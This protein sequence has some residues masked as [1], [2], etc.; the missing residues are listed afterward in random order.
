MTTVRI[1]ASGDGDRVT[2]NRLLG[3][4]TMIP[5]R[6]I[7]L[8]E[9]QFLVDGLFRQGPPAGNGAVAYRLNNPLFAD[10]DPEIVE[11]YGEIPVVGTS[12]GLLKTVGTVKRGFAL[13]VSRE[14]RD[15]NDTATLNL[16][17]Q[18]LRNSMVRAW[19]RAFMNLIDSNTGG[20]EGIHLMAAGDGLGKTS[21]SWTEPASGEDPIRADL[22]AAMEVIMNSG[23]NG[24]DDGDDIFE[25][26]AN[27]LVI[28]TTVAVN[29][30]NNDAVNEVFAHGALADE[31][32]K[33]TGK[34]PRKFF[35]L[36]V[37][38]SR[39]LNKSGAALVMQR[40]IAGF[41]SDE[42][43]LEATAMYP[44]QDRETWRSNITRR[45]AIALDQPKA[46]VRIDGVANPA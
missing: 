6:Q 18:Q 23:P 38:Q 10:E 4:P 31:Q 5:E 22:A 44:D 7:R 24:I 32:L 45:S 39:A 43:P 1:Q 17:M 36:D 21:T 26:E 2:V 35:G 16:R 28:P 14:M 12:R 29:F 20:D 8:L 37:V 41:I 42:R 34:M 13:V 40:G 30:L 46:I 9:N 33:Y 15:R 11:E 19:D 27:T 3:N 25:F